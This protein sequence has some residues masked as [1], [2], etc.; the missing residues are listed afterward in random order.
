MCQSK[1]TRVIMKRPQGPPGPVSCMRIIDRYVIREVLWPFLLG[2]VVFTFILI[3]PF[4]IQYAEQFV[5]KGVPIVVVAQVMATL[6]PMSLSL[7]IPMSLL[8]GLLVA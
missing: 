5:S 2:L 8:L 1:A 3:I 7:S 6:L 4:L